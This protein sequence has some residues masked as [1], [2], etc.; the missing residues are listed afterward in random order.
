MQAVGATQFVKYGHRG[1]W[2][3]DVSVGVLIKHLLDAAQ[4]SGEA[5]TAWLSQAMSD[6]RV[7]AVISDC[8]FT[9]DEHWSI[10]QRKTIIALIGQAC[11]E[12][13]TRRSIPIEEIVS[14]PFAD[15]LRIF[16][17]S[18]KEVPT[19]PIVE[20]GCAMIALLSDALP[21]AP[22]NEAWFFGAPDG[23]STIRMD[24][25]WDGRW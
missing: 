14:W 10:E 23:R 11:A 2:G 20:L 8:G 9:F 17:R 19:A 7:W 15:N 22:N 6:W 18:A 12:I 5:H 3:Y 4:K 1:F 16:P 21:E 24:P 13:A 25:S